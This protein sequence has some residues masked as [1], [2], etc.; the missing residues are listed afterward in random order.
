MQL[1]KVGDRNINVKNY[2]IKKTGRHLNN[3]ERQIKRQYKKETNDDIDL[4]KYLTKEEQKAWERL[5]KW[6]QDKMLRKAILKVEGKNNER[7]FHPTRKKIA[8]ASDIPAKKQVHS[9]ELRMQVIKK[10]QSRQRESSLEERTQKAKNNA[11][12]EEQYAKKEEA[13]AKHPS[14]VK[15][16]KMKTIGAGAW[17]ISRSVARNITYATDDLDD[18]ENS[19][20]VQGGSG[21]NKASKTSWAQ[22]KSEK[23]DKKKSKQ[24][25]GKISNKLFNKTIGGVAAFQSIKSATADTRS[26]RKAMDNS[27]SGVLRAVGKSLSMLKS[28]AL[29]ILA[30]IMPFLLV[31]GGIIGC[32]V[33]IV[34]L[35]TTLLGG[36]ASS[37][38][39]GTY[40][41]YNDTITY[42]T[43]KYESGGDANNTG[44]DGGNACGMFQFDCRYELPWFV[45]WCLIQ[46]NQ[47][48]LYDPFRPYA[49]SVAGAL[50][51][52][53]A[54]FNAWHR[55]YETNAV[56]FDADQCEYVI[57]RNLNVDFLNALT[58]AS[59][60]YDFNNAPPAVLGMVL[61]FANRDG[62][63]V[64][65][66][67]R[68]FSG[69]SPTTSAEELITT[70]YDRMINRR[71]MLARWPLEKADCLAI[72][73]G[74]LDIYAPSS[75]AAGHID[76][77]YKRNASVEGSSEI[78]QNAI[79][80]MNQW[81]GAGW[82][83]SQANRGNGGFD[84]SYFAYQSCLLAGIDIGSDYSA[85]MAQNI[86]NAGGEISVSQLQPGD[87]VFYHTNWNSGPRWRG[88]NHVAV[89]IGNGQTADAGSAPIRVLDVFQKGQPVMCGRPSA[90]LK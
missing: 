48:G 5:P 44:G 63:N 68:Y 2:Q 64:Q 52:H 84:C 19:N 46:K 58:T 56:Q 20:S 60:G 33:V 15:A 11:I 79:N 12:T 73:N 31:L 71:P 85:G 36:A 87:L 27:A 45:D 8:R 18:E 25:A 28:I 23:G 21:G 3:H 37:N 55:V 1:K 17:R 66:V 83:Y 82:V 34:V 77:S 51:S 81:N 53:T 90:M 50:K 35:I 7:S 78:A 69:F 39:V 22:R 72:L 13:G 61:S 49:N 16:S 30:P 32:I 54:F 76:W 42:L 6:K 80:L 24:I 65:S 67:G 47:N 14:E 62:N 26:T 29:A 40:N 88:I 10:Q 38:N 89:Y 86:Y 57:M 41:S 9:E 75:N 4:A 43:A 74:T 70:A 59:G